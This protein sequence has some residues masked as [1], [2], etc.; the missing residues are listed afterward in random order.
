[1]STA[2]IV[3]KLWNYCSVLRDDGM[4]YGDYMVSAKKQECDAIG[5][6]LAAVAAQQLQ[7]STTA[8]AEQ[9]RKLHERRFEK[10]CYLPE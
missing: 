4:S 8:L 3:S 7:Y 6:Q 1:M 2:D 10:R 9:K 5:Q